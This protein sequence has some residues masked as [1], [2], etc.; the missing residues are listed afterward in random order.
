MKE[1]EF[2]HNKAMDLAE[3]SATARFQG[4]A[5]KAQAYLKQAYENELEAIKH[6]RGVDLEPSRSIIFRSAASLALECQEYR[7]AERLI[8]LALAG[9]PQHEIAEEL[10]DL[11]EQVNFNR[12]LSL[13]GYTLAEDE[14]QLSIAGQAVGFGMALTG[15]IVTRIQTVEKLIL[16]S[17]ER[18]ANKPFREKGPPRRA[19]RKDLQLFM[20]VPRA[21]SFAVSFKVGQPKG[22]DRLPGFNYPADI[23][24]ELMSCLQMFDQQR[25]NEL[26]EKIPDRAYFTNF[27]A[28]VRD[29][30]PDG[31]Q[32]KEVGLT[33]I[34]R[35]AEIHVPITR[36]RSQISLV[37][38]IAPTQD[39]GKL[40]K[41]EGQLLL[42]DKTRKHREIGLVD[43]KGKVHRVLVPEGMMSDI[44]KPLW[45][46]T[47][48]VEGNRV[49]DVINLQ[50]I[51]EASE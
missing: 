23:I 46:C 17:A 15:Q 38:S 13:R 47:V 39:R 34:R 43:K 31:R 44:V 28:L 49:D 21:A 42:A 8:S 7:E 32:V 19:L 36:K 2:Y 41:V 22:M 33:T 37:S 11:F 20:A 45:E 1:V 6:L 12:H 18:L 3:M 5:E 16:R 26:R 9:N 14:F 35:G 25:E 48:V 24:D 29:V 40:V 4:D 27:V 30:A 51:R 10:R 50:D